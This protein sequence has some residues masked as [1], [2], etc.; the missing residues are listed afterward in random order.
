MEPV[1]N[2]TNYLKLVYD[3]L[4]L[5]SLDEQTKV[6]LSQFMEAYHQTLNAYLNSE[7]QNPELSIKLQQ[8]S[9]PVRVALNTPN[10]GHPHP[11]AEFIKQREQQNGMEMEKGFDKV[12]KNPNAPSIINEEDNLQINGYS[13][14]FIIIGITLVLGIILGKLLFVISK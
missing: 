3:S 13:L 5:N 9:G 14:A 4:K 8:L 7:V 12:L 10:D 6:L 2:S 1:E 11:A